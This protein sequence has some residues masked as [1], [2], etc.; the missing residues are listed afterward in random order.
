MQLAIAQV[1]NEIKL[2][3]DEINS[4]LGLKAEINNST[5]P[6]DVGITSQVL[7]SVMG[8]LENKLDVTIPHNKYIFHDKKTN[9]HL[10]IKEAS[11][12]LM[13]IAK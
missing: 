7:V 12:K 10:S 3:I 2:I 11:I 1:E 9:K 13:K 6:H 8:I 5:C 4:N